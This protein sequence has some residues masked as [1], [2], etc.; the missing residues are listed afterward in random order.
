[1]VELPWSL[2]LRIVLT[3]AQSSPHRRIQRHRMKCSAKPL[4]ADG[5]S[6]PCRMKDEEGCMRTENIWNWE[7]AM[8]Y[9]SDTLHLM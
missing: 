3:V 6:E 7:V 9:R 4:G 5:R 1:V 8:V 2:Y